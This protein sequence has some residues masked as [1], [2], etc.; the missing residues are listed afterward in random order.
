M[1]RNIFEKRT[2]DR[3]F[4]QYWLETWK[5]PLILNLEYCSQLSLARLRPN[6]WQPTATLRLH[7]V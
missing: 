7:Y 5:D 4:I 6:D 3:G 1:M 2:V